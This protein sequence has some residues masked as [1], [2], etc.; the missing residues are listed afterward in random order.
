MK[1]PIIIKVYNDR[2]HGWGAV[3]RSLLFE[4]GLLNRISSYSYQK[5]NTVY[6]EED[7]D[8]NLVT[9]RL[10]KLGADFTFIEKYTDRRSPIRSYDYFRP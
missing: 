8:L 10:V 2:G 9:Q 7:V 3:K 5:G 4:L 6:L 1:Q